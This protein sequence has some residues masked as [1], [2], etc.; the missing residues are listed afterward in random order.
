[1][2]TITAIGLIGSHIQGLQLILNQSSL[3][4]NFFDIYESAVG[5]IKGAFL[6]S[7]SKLISV[8]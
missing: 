8:R 1:M 3:L 5:D 6:Q 7:V 2:V 4:Q